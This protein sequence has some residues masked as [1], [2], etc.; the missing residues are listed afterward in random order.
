MA[1]LD[2]PYAS[3]LAARALERMPGHLSPGGR[4]YVEGAAPVAAGA[5]WIALR[6]D[7]AGAV[8]Y[9]LLELAPT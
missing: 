4:V 1:F 3:D 9:A 8:R 7:R 5:P 6:E 2:P